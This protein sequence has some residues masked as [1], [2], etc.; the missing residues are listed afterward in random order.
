MPTHAPQSGAAD[1]LDLHGVIPPTL[2]AFDESERVDHGATAAHAE[3]VVDRGAHAVFPLGT[4]GEFPLLGADERATVVETVV[5][6]VGD[7]V[8]VI[9]GVGAPSTRETI[10]H[11]ER[12]VA[13]GADGLVVVTPYYFPLD[14]QGAVEHYRQV[15]TAVDRPIYV[16]HF[17]ART[18][19]ALAP[20][21]MR[22]IAAI[23]GVAGLK[24]TS[25]DVPWLDRV[26]ADSPD[27]TYLAGSNALLYTGL[28]IGCAGV[29]SSVANAFPELVVD[30]YTA[31]GEGDDE[32]AR[33]IQDRVHG[34]LEA[35]DRG[36]YMASVKTA[37]ALREPTLDLGP[38][39]SP[40][41]RLGDAETEALAEDLSE[42]DLL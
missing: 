42:L 5:D 18:G 4:N 36:P 37:L 14:R 29:V 38:L 3:F 21:T 34:V 12:A 27:L 13:A 23:E 32:R 35:F 17:P 6:A 9:A 20:E 10:R 22:E 26:M 15:A 39:R 8:P 40:L 2:T 25:E 7:E 41:R 19:N 24:D 1:P 30:L 11:A 33:A 16:Y 31:V 28:A